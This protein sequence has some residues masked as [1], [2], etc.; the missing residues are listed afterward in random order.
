MSKTRYEWTLCDAAIWAAGAVTV[1]VYE[2]SSADQLEWILGD[3]G[4]VAA[5][6]ETP[7]H[8]RRLAGLTERLREL[9]DHWVI[10]GKDAGHTLASLIEAGREV[11]D[12]ELDR[13]RANLN[14]DKLATIIIT[15]RRARPADRRAASSP[16]ATSWPRSPARSRRC[17]NSSRARTPVRCC[18]CRS[19]MSSAG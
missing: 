9:R 11:D 7:G 12:A 15:T 13:R 17:Q 8:D 3:S 1:P 19:R 5:I 18:S 4:A 14:A 6:V 16:T 2:T 10:D